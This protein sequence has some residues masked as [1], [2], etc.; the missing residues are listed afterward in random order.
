ME[1][2]RE[3]RCPKSSPFALDA[4][5]SISE[6]E[7]KAANQACTNGWHSTFYGVAGKEGDKRSKHLHG[8]SGVALS[9]DPHWKCLKEERLNYWSP[10]DAVGQKKNRVNP[11]EIPVILAKHNRDH[12]HRV[13]D[14]KTFE[15]NP[16]TE[17]PR[18]SLPIALEMRLDPIHC[19]IFRTRASVRL[20]LRDDGGIAPDAIDLDLDGEGFRLRPARQDYGA[21][22]RRINCG[23]AWGCAAA[24]PYRVVD[25]RRR[26]PK[27]KTMAR[28][29]G[30][31]ST[32]Q[33][34][35]IVGEGGREGNVVF[36]QM[37]VGG[38]S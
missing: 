34:G 23:P 12:G 25:L 31:Q 32:G 26:L 3:G 38:A 10:C 36:A 19:S 37:A 15:G 5:V 17:G 1:C 16:P 35:W 8:E 9:R 20:K 18:R 11:A 33:H 13:R 27:G 2:V 6:C 4:P 28:R 24:Q 30:G 7:I 22:S 21:T 29:G 14:N